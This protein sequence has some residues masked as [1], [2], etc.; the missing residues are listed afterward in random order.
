MKQ[1]KKIISGCSAVLMMLSSIT[2][3]AQFLGSS[4]PQSFFPATGGPYPIPTSTVSRPSWPTFYNQRNNG[5]C[6]NTEWNI[7]PSSP[8]NENIYVWAINWEDVAGHSTVVAYEIKNAGNTTVLYRGTKYVGADYANLNVGLYKANGGSVHVAVAYWSAGGHPTGVGVIKLD[9]FS[10]SLSSGLSLSSST[11]LY[12][13][14]N[15]TGEAQ[16]IGMD[17]HDSTAITVVWEDVGYGVFIEG[18][19]VPSGGAGLTRSY[20]MQVGGAGGRIPDV[21][22][23]H[24]TSTGRREAHVVL[25]NT[26]V[27]R[28]EKYTIDFDWLAL[29]GM[30]TPVLEDTEPCA[31]FGAY[32]DDF[33]I[34]IDAPDHHSAAQSDWAYTFFDDDA[35]KIKAK[36]CNGGT[37][38]S[39]VVNN[40]TIPTAPGGST[41]LWDITNAGNAFPTIT[42]NPSG[43]AVYVGWYTNYNFGG[44]PNP[45]LYNYSGTTMGYVSV[46]LDITGFL[47]TNAY[48][49]IDNDFNTNRI[50]AFI[51]PS[52]PWTDYNYPKVCFSKHNEGPFLFT[53]FASHNAN[54]NLLWSP[55]APGTIQSTYHEKPGAVPPTTFSLILANLGYVGG[56]ILATGTS[57]YLSQKY[58]SWSTLLPV[59]RIAKKESIVNAEI[60]TV[61]SNPFSETEIF[62]L[63]GGVENLIYRVV[64][65]SLDG[66]RLAEYSG[67]ISELN[68]KFNDSRIHNLPVGVYQLQ[69]DNKSS[70]QSFKLIKE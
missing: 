25:N 39:Y 16:H 15:M 58:S 46:V 66:K 44:V 13:M 3:D 37:Y 7:D 26:S 61:A 65:R 60:I 42:Y 4:Q 34:K 17:C 69:L 10:L 40:G 2:V 1:L 43:N 52:N 64:L 31:L 55:P 18:L 56:G 51:D 12:Y 49:R 19:E 23:N 54:T 36:V 27:P 33:I 48:N 14:Q 45:P 47:R 41:F 5:S 30:P 32:W 20:P 6:Y 62:Q 29:G 70:I 68:R 57:V 22:L 24:N 53:L 11:N 67:N 21:A 50:G 38:T 9:D 35:N 63:K 28:I 8:G 59:F